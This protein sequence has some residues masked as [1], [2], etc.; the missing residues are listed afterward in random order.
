VGLT[1]IIKNINEFKIYNYNLII[2][3]KN[4]NINKYILKI[5]KISIRQVNT[6]LIYFS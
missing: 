6:N 5:N 3:I 2:C 1:F 4:V